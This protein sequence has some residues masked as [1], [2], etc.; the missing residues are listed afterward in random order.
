MNILH[1][2]TLTDSKTNGVCVIVPQ[3]VE[4]QSE[5][6]NVR[7]VNIRNYQ[8]AGDLQLEYK[9][10][11]TFPDYLEAPFNR[12]DLVI[13]HEV[14]NFEYI[15]L[16]KQLLKRKIPY[17]ILPHGELTVKSLRKKFLKKKLAYLL[18][19]NRFVKKSLGLQCLSEN[20]KGNIR[21]K[22]PKFVA[23]NGVQIPEEKKSTFSE[24]GVKFIYVGRLEVDIKGLD[25]MIEGVAKNAGLFRNSG[26]TLDIYGP[27]ILGRGRQVLDLIAA[28]CVQDIITMHPPVFGEDKKEVLLGG[29]I[30]IQT[31]RTEG[32][33]LGITEALAYG[34]PCLITEGTSIG[35]TVNG[36][37][38]GW[39]ATTDSDSV[40]RQIAEVFE[41]KESFAEKSLN[42]RLAAEKEF[43]WDI[44]AA[45]AVEEYRALTSCEEKERTNGEG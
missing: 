13:F 7:L 8:V 35:G 38:A 1:V 37:G 10:S 3:H 12:P 36:Y 11:K 2:A 20:E 28:N 39:V 14:N 25:L 17:V 5:I 43:G 27:D 31:S 29:D 23:T 4:H 40:A 41:Q 44:I 16:Y 15:R 21:F 42:A 26:S 24:N 30:F 22:V 45:K 18:F 6:E 33:P 9:G 34:L 19:F 32:M